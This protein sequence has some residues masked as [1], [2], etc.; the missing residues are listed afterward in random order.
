MQINDS[1]VYKLPNIDVKKAQIIKANNGKNLEKSESSEEVYAQN[2]DKDK[3]IVHSIY[4]RF[5]DIEKQ[6]HNKFM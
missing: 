3:K 4:S 6:E 5:S 2:Y 1:Y